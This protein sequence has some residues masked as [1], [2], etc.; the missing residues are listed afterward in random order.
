MSDDRQ[1]RWTV[2]GVVMI[3]AVF[4]FV[5]SYA[6]I[7]DL[8]LTHGQHGIAAKGMPLSVDLLIVAASLVLF[9]QARAD[10]AAAGLARFLPRLL[11]WAGIAATVA[12]NVAYGWPF[13]YLGAVISAWPGAV[14]AGLAELVMVTARP[15]PP[16]APAGVSVQPYAQA[17]PLIP[18]SAYEA[19][20]AAFAATAAGPN[21]I[22]EYQLS[23]RYG[24]P[25]SQARKICAPAVPELAAASLNGDGPHE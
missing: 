9:L 17:G 1:I 20:Q 14:F 7:Y 21:P 6:H 11:L 22:S 23:K 16:A 18:G 8:G 4:A 25:R 13:G 3:V 10:T 15:Q 24:I 12:A 19:A 2:Y 5:V